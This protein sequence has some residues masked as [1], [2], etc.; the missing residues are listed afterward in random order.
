MLNPTCFFR[1]SHCVSYALRTLSILFYIVVAFAAVEEANAQEIDVFGNTV[2]IPNGS[3]TPALGNHTDF[4]E[5]N[6]DSGTVSRTFT[7]ENPGAGVLTLGANAVAL[8]GVNAKDFTVTAQPAL[9]VAAGSST[10]FSVE[11]N[12]RGGG[13]RIALISIANNAK[14]PY[15]FRDI[16]P[17]QYSRGCTNPRRARNRRLWQLYYAGGKRFSRRQLFRLYQRGSQVVGG[18]RSGGR[19]R[20]RRG[21]EWLR[22]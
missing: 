2:S 6:V 20:R 1:T 15:I 17:G 14:N 4:G 10:T 5:R 13:C 18:R 19:D 22:G 7:I 8:S 11:F 12:P 16:R 21:E 3:T 9:S